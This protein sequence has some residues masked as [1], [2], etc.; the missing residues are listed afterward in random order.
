MWHDVISSR[1]VRTRPS[2]GFFVLDHRCAQTGSRT[3][4]DSYPMGTAG[5][6]VGPSSWL[7]TSMWCRG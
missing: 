3:H 2:G 1:K 6:A 4:P 5:K 7:L